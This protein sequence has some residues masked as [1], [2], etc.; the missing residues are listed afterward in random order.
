MVL[1]RSVL[2]LEQEEEEFGPEEGIHRETQ[3]KEKH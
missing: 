3:R 1:Q 2:L